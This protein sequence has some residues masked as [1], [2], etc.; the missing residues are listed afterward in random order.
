MCNMIKKMKD[1]KA[2]GAAN[3][4]DIAKHAKEALDE[5][6]MFKAALEKAKR[7]GELAWKYG[8]P[9]WETVTAVKN[10]V[11]APMDPFAYKGLIEQ[12]MKDYELTKEAM[13]PERVAAIKNK[14]DGVMSAMKTKLGVPG[15]D[16]A[17]CT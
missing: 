7:G 4:E 11:A 3:A 5:H 8:V 12:L 14:A 9:M 1:A 15:G 13:G 2:R 10:V 17:N 16:S 6:P